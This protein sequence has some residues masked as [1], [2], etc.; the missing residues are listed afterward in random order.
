MKLWLKGES[1]EIY[2]KRNEEK[3]MVA[4]QINQTIKN[5]NQKHILAVSKLPKTN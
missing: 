2:L 1:I 5:K 4:K 3:S